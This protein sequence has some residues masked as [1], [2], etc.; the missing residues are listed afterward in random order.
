VR[1]Q[2]DSGIIR[3]ISS[4]ATTFQ[5][6]T[7]GVSVTTGKVQFEAASL[8]ASGPVSGAPGLAV[9]TTPSRNHRGKNVQVSAGKPPSKCVLETPTTTEFMPSLSN[10]FGSPIDPSV[11]GQRMD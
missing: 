2:P 3:P 8:Q 9:D 11:T 7:F 10:M 4:R 1:N 6:A 5:V